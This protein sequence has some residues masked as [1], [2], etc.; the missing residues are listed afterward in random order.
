M[1]AQTT[2]RGHTMAE[3][4]FGR[5]FEQINN[6][7]AQE[8]RPLRIRYQAACSVVPA[9]R[10]SRAQLPVVDSQLILN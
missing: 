5:Q 9:M 10:S 1:H 7:N 6:A 3:S 4:S 2:A 8:A